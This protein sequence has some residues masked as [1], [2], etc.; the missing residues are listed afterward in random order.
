MGDY[1][2]MIYLIYDIIISSKNKDN[3]KNNNED[4]KCSKCNKFYKTKKSLINHE[5]SCNGLSILTCPKCMKI[6]SHINNKNK[7]I[8]KNNCKAKSINN[9]I[10]DYINNYGNERIDYLEDFINKPDIKDLPIHKR[11]IKYIEYKYFNEE[12]PE[13]KNIKYKNNNCLIRE[14]DKW[15]PKDL[16]N[17]IIDIIEKNKSIIYTDDNDNNNDNNDIKN[18]LKVLIKSSK[19]I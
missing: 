13:N 3:N 2:S 14:D 10:N 7:H 8:K 5:K 9:N 1:N 4:N 19:S 18:E 6:F 11:L 16:N 12:F 15:K 17:I